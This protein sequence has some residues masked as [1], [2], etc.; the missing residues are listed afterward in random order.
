M[1]RRFSN[2]KY[3]LGGLKPSHREMLARH[4]R[5][6]DHWIQPHGP[7]PAET[8]INLQPEKIYKEE[9]W[10]NMFRFYYADCSA[11]A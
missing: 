2:V 6:A 4:P 1:A 7:Q 9:I 3:L 8:S 10:E 5:D 11:S